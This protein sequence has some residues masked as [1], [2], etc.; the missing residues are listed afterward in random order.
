LV[1]SLVTVPFKSERDNTYAVL[2]FSLSLPLSLVQLPDM[3]ASS[4]DL[5]P[6]LIGLE[7]GAGGQKSFS[8][9][10]SSS[11][12][13]M[14]L[15]GCCVLIDRLAVKYLCDSRDDA[16]RDDVRRGDERRGTGWRI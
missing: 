14:N 2:L 11:C 3:L 15:Y 6:K 10:L 4:P 7:G 9:S 1:H 5:L 12:L 13:E 8:L 16:W